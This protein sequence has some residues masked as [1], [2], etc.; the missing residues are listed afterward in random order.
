MA[1]RSCGS[2][3]LPK[4]KGKYFLFAEP[5]AFVQANEP[6]DVERC[7]WQLQDY[8]DAGNFVAGYL[9]YE[10]AAGLNPSMSQAVHTSQPNYPLLYFG[11]YNA[12]TEI[13][14][15][16]LAMQTVENSQSENWNLNWQ[17]DITQHEYADN[18]QKIKSAIA[19]GD[20]YQV[21]YSFRMKTEFNLDPLQFFLK[22]QRAQAS[23]FSAYMQ[24]DDF[25][26]CSASPEL[27]FSLQSGKLLAKP[28]KG[29]INR[30]LHKAQ[31]AQRKAWLL[32][33]EKNR[34][35]NLMIVDML[36]NDLGQ[37][38]EVGSVNVDTLF[39]IETYPTVFQMTSSVRAETKHSAIDVL[40]KMF[41][42]ASITGAPKINT[43]K[44]I[45]ELEASA[46]GIYTGSMGYITPANDALFNVAIRTVFIDSLAKTASYGV[47]GG[48]VW[49]ST[50][51]DE[52]KECRFKAEILTREPPDLKLLESMY[53]NEQK[54]IYLWDQHIK[55]LRETSEYFGFAFSEQSVSKQIQEALNGVSGEAAKIRLLLD[56]QG[57][58]DLEFQDLKSKVGQRVGVSRER[59]NTQSRFVY[60]KTSQ[61]QFYLSIL[62]KIPLDDVIIV[63]LEGRVTESCFANIAIYKGEDLITPPLTD[64]LLNGT[65]RSM[66]LEKKIITETPISLED[67]Q[68]AKQ[69][70]LL[71]SVRGWMK[72]EKR[73]SNLEGL[74]E[75]E[76]VEESFQLPSLAGPGVTVGK[77]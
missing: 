77:V 34:A 40:M 35:E 70:Y 22:L 13:S 57:N 9:A 7:L 42:C 11:V 36:R 27:F 32:E 37:V 74:L 56:A 75:Y 25:Q 54:E 18:I 55:R 30:G 64:G 61:R 50:A 51:K 67:L 72:L 41:P 15:H 68:N 43:M 38:A 62:D 6:K 1:L 45:A 47:G 33:S 73:E 65:F 19:A 8:L 5:K 26:I 69:A 3:L 29:T 58:V 71:N 49:D 48:I 23:E 53:M 20:T 31:D 59:S 2:M 16:T 14:L 10:A 28:M 76:I 66:L 63:N 52:Y 44:I 12:P 39:D 60:H 46:R 4:G 17:A 24:F 21:N